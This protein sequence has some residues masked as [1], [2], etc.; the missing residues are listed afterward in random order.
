MGM[1]VLE[2][3][4]RLR[5]GGS[6]RRELYELLRLR[7]LHVIVLGLLIRGTRSAQHFGW[8]MAWE[9]VILKRRLDDST[10]MC[11]MSICINYIYCNLFRQTFIRP[12]SGKGKV[13]PLQARCGPEG[14]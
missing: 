9:E 2:R 4:D 13:I 11:L 12:S 7:A 3:T 10:K 8:E 1:V 5:V 14:G 6:S